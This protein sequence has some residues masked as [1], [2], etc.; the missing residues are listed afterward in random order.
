MTSQPQHATGHLDS[1]NH[2]TD[3]NTNTDTD[4]HTL[5]SSNLTSRNP[6]H[7][8]PQNQPPFQQSN[9]K[10]PITPPSFIV[11]IMI[12]MIGAFAFLQVYSIQAILPIMM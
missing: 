8:Q 7:S 2:S 4:T 10:P 3:T 11:K 12:G 6:S 1:S 5:I 9:A